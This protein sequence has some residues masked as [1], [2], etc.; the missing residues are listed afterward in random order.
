MSHRTGR[1][2]GRGGLASQQLLN[3]LT[4]PGSAGMGHSYGLRRAGTGVRSPS[5]GLANLP[6]ELTATMD[7]ISSLRLSGEGLR[8][9]ARDFE[10]TALR[11]GCVLG[12]GRRA[13]PHS[14]EFSVCPGRSSR[15]KL[16]AA[17]S[18]LIRSI[19][20]N[21]TDST[22]MRSAFMTVFRQLDTNKSGML[23][24]DELKSGLRTL[25]HP[26]SDL[27]AQVLRLRRMHTCSLCEVCWVVHRPS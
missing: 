8:P 7:S 12:L 14:N 1:T 21:V 18:T 2:G 25:G 16:D 6:T 15:E 23:S 4:S 10:D 20:D 11:L 17:E 24:L 22:S 27:E 9:G 26:L 13:V 5:P 3:S 19:Q